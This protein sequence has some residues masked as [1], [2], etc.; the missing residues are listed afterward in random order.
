VAEGDDGESYGSPVGGR[1]DS[2]PLQR[3]SPIGDPKPPAAWS[4]SYFHDFF[5]DG[6]WNGLAMF[7]QTLQITGDSFLDVLLGFLPGFTLRNAAGQSGTLR[8]KHAVFVLFD[9]YSEFHF[10]LSVILHSSGSQALAWE[11]K[12]FCQA[13]LGAS[14]VPQRSLGTRI[15]KLGFHFLFSILSLTE[16]R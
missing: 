2:Q 16:I 14:G 10:N 3:P 13:E 6:R 11:P 4:Y 5:G 1:K 15:T 9:D 8:H 12:I 7:F